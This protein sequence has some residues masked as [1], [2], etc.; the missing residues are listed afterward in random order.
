MLAVTV[1]LKKSGFLRNL[2]KIT[3]LTISRSLKHLEPYFRDILKWP[4]EAAYDELDSE[5]VS[6]TG[7]SL[8]PKT[9]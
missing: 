1:I 6:V 7:S 2:E 5:V 9:Y 8:G 3:K 4:R